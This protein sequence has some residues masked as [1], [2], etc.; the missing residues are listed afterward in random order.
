[1]VTI[2]RTEFPVVLTQVKAKTLSVVSREAG[3]GRV[4][5]GKPG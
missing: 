3:L 5:V 2:L 1:L 4:Q